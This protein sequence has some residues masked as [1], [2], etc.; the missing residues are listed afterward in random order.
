MKISYSEI[1]KTYDNHRSY[2]ELHMEPLIRFAN[3]KDGMKILDVRVR[4]R[5]FCCNVKGAY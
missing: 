3:L 2:T 5:E 1:S 4:D